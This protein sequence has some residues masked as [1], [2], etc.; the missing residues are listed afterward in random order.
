[1][2]LTVTGILTLELAD[3]DTGEVI[4]RREV[5]NLVTTGGLAALAS[6]VNW[7][8]ISDVAASLGMPSPY[9]LAPVYGAVGTSA[10]APAAGDVSL[11]AE[12]ARAAVSDSAA[13]T[14]QSTWSFFYGATQANG[15][16]AEVGAFASATSVPGSGILLDHALVSPALTKTNT[17]TLTMQVS[18]TLASA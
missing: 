16:I 13:A 8:G 17:Q 9:Q 2:E 15:T 14:G 10:T 4:E 11:G 5:R 6:A 12:I 18:F 7:S 3:A 1:M